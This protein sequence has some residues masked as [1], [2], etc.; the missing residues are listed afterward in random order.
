MALLAERPSVT[1]REI[2]KSC[3]TRIDKVVRFLAVLE[4]IK[5]GQAEVDQTENFGEITVRRGSGDARPDTGAVDEYE[6][7][8]IIDPEVQG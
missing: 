8:P 5:R 2:T 1:F 7:A 3:S 6:G 4:L